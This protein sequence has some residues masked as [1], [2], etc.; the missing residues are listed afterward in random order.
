MKIQSVNGIPKPRE[1]EFLFVGK[2]L[3]IEPK[4]GEKFDWFVHE[5]GEFVGKVNLPSGVGPANSKR[6][7]GEFG[8]RL[9]LRLHPTSKEDVDDAE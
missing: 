5:W 4:V 7:S 3:P 8:F 9:R 2:L 6:E 1:P